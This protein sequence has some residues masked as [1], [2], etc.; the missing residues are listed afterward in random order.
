MEPGGDVFVVDFH[1]EWMSTIY[2]HPCEDGDGDGKNVDRLKVHIPV[3]RLIM[4]EVLKKTNSDY[5]YY[6]WGVWLQQLMYLKYR[7]CI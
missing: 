3:D 2:T 5:V 6:L 1:I 4:V 7:F